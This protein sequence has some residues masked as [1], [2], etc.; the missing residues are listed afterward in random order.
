VTLK[1]RLLFFIIGAAFLLLNS[2]R[3]VF[4]EL[5]SLDKLYSMMTSD[6]HGA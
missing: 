4:P 1:A 2:L 5:F 6:D 3:D